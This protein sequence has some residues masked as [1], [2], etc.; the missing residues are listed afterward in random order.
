MI[1][2]HV[3]KRCVQYSAMMVISSLMLVANGGLSFYAA[4]NRLS[5]SVPEISW[6]CRFLEL[7]PYSLVNPDVDLLSQCPPSTNI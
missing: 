1:V 7:L 2:Q 4:I 5:I 3:G 6:E